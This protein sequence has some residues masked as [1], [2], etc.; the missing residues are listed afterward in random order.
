MIDLTVEQRTDEAGRESEARLRLAL[1]AAHTATWDWG[2]STGELIWS[3]NATA[4][5]G[6][7]ASAL[8]NSHVRFL[9]F[10]H[11]DDRA[12]LCLTDDTTIADGISY[13]VE[14]RVTGLDGKARWFSNHGRVL[15]REPD[16]R[17]ARIAGVTIDIT[18]RKA[19][20]EALS[21]S[22]ARFRSLVQ[23]A[24]DMISILDANGLV[25]YEAPAVERVLGYTSAELVGTNPFSRI[26]ED[27]VP[28]IRELLAEILRRPRATARSEFRYRHKDGSW[29]W[30]EAI[31]TNMLDDRNVAGIVVNTRDVTARKAAEVALREAEVRY[32]TLVERLPAIVSTQHVDQDALTTTYVSPQ[33]AAIL[34]YSPEEIFT[35]GVSWVDLIHPDDREHVLAENARTNANGEPFHAEYRQRAHDGCW[36]WMRDEAVLVPGED[37]Q[38]DYWLSVQFDVTARKVAEEALRESECRERQL[39]AAARRHVRELML[40]DK[41]RTT[42]AHELELSVLLRSVVTVIAEVFGYTQVSLY[43]VEGDH[44]V[45]QHQVGYPRQLDRIPVS[46][47]VMGRVVRSGEP[48]LVTDV[49]AEPA[50]L[51][52][53][54][55]VISEVC[56]PLRADG[57]VVGALNVESTGGV[58]LTDADLRLVWAVGEHVDIALGRARL[59][60]AVRTSESR[61]R[62]MV[63]NVSDVIA[64]VG[65]DGLLRYLSP[66]IEWI[67]GHAPDQL[68]G[69]SIFS[70]V[71]PDDEE[72]ALEAFA[73]Y[74]WDPKA[75]HRVEV[76]LRHRDG[77][78]RWLEIVGN[79]APEGPGLDGL[80]LNARDVTERKV[81]EADART[82]AGEQAALLRV[83]QA[84]IS[85]QPLS[86]VLAEVTRAA[87]GLAGAE[88][89]GIDLWHPETDELE[90]AS[91]ET[92]P[93]WPGVEAPGRRYALAEWPTSR[94]ALQRRKPLRF[95]VDDPAVPE[96]ERRRYAAEGIGSV[97][98]IP[99]LLGEECLG[100]LNL[101]SREFRPFSLAAVHFGQEFAAAAAQ[102]ID[103][104]RLA[105]AERRQGTRTAVLLRVAAALNEA[106]SLK[107]LMPA[108]AAAAA[109]GVDC[110]E[111]H[112]Y[113]EEASA[114]V[115]SGYFGF[116][117]GSEHLAAVE[118]LPPRRFPAEAEVI[119][120]RRPLFRGIETPFPPPFPPPG[121]RTDLV[122]PLL[123]AGSTQGVLYVWETDRERIFAE[124]EVALLRRSGTKPRSPS[125][126]LGTPPWPNG[127][128]ST[129]RSSTSLAARSRPV[130]RSRISAPSSTARWDASLPPTPS[131][132]RCTSRA[133]MK[134][135]SHICSTRGGGAR[136]SGCRSIA[137]RP[138]TSCGRTVPTYGQAL[139]IRSSPLARFSATASGARPRRCT[140]R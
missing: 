67:L 60:A 35:G 98:L 38:L 138:A 24:S 135:G 68:V 72:S 41:V 115:A 85:G 20:E 120:T 62:A 77:S 112:A 1:E 15:E 63:Q 4:V 136:R 50:F 113:D 17:A 49:R 92:I 74:V 30:L 91:E 104:T 80:V 84:V 108:L 58:T 57:R 79:S 109:I 36:V 32:R 47:G 117:F 140:C 6:L 29:R 116:E 139:T 2:I 123:A 73:A 9:D 53:I 125:S 56:V 31:G 69:Q 94:A 70:L 39:A 26:H 90:V 16:G 64:V 61:F 102:A 97:L 118:G 129:W 106:G 52:A 66:A 126:V 110:A 22:E 88:C 46:E 14:Y 86:A 96:H 33:V 7:P 42:L 121:R 34:G 54:A 23:H 87:L 10:I 89:C 130:W 71:H 51:S 21:A 11:S 8:G 119:R 55:G 65:T 13:A 95:V 100:M 132:S 99:L 81:A 82:R 78:W 76:R 27:D 83:S 28:R 105:E 18:E 59:H 101:Y 128:R 93:E 5:F 103:R 131:S 40:L 107:E 111:V 19:A 122:V 37:G 3:V 127:G 25:R 48:A 133:R 12:R 75:A 44:L 43:L 137:A 134:S 124:D 114:T 45:L